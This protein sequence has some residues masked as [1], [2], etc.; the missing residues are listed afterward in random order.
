MNS[1]EKTRNKKLLEDLVTSLCDIERAEK[2]GDTRC[3]KER[4]RFG[5]LFSDTLAQLDGA[6][7]PFQKDDLLRLR[8]GP[9]S[10]SP[11]P[12]SGD[13]VYRVHRMNYEGEDQW[14]VNLVETKD[15]DDQIQFGSSLFEKV[16]IVLA[17]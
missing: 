3:R 4:E 5:E 9:T 12:L 7:A 2:R 17:S 13:T 15:R 11:H 8:A 10:S 6:R 16:A 1:I 14:M